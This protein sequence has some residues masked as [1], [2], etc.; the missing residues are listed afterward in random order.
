MSS[1]RRSAAL[2]LTLLLFL[3]LVLPFG[4]PSRRLRGQLP[5][6]FRASWDRA[7]A[8][9]RD[10]LEATGMVGASWAFFSEGRYVAH[11]V[12]GYAD[13]DTQ[14]RVDEATIYHWGSITKTLT[15]IAI[16]Q[17]RDR[18]LLHLDDP[19]LNYVPELRG[20]YNP[21]VDM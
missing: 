16:M 17:L 7:S 15:G 13:L 5:P 20:V 14:R 19:I 10:T 21:F 8:E 1:D 18:G 4:Q 11:E 2:S 3:T 9:L 6:T 12:Y